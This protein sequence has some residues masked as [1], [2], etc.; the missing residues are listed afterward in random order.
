[1]TD[2]DEAM[3]QAVDIGEKDVSII[4]ELLFDL[5]FSIYLDVLLEFVMQ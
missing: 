3:A 2:M 4:A 5:V 1:M